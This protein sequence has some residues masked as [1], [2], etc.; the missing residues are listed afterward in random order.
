MRKTQRFALSHFAVHIAHRSSMPHVSLILLQERR[1]LIKDMAQYFIP[2]NDRPVSL[3]PSL[4][5]DGDGKLNRPATARRNS[6]IETQAAVRPDLSQKAEPTQTPYP[7]PS[8]AGNPTVVP[9]AVLEQF[10]F[11]FLIRHPR[12]SIP[13]Y[14]RCTIPP[15]D[16]L[17]GFHN[18]RS[19]EAGYAELRQMFD[20][21]RRMGYVGP[22]IAGEE[23]ETD[24]NGANG[25]S[26]QT[27][28]CVVDA[29]DLL[30]KPS[31]VIEAFCKSVGIDYSP[32]MLTWT[33]EQ[34]KEA[35]EAFAKWKGFHED[36]LHSHDLKPRKHVSAET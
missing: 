32:Q 6:H 26:S 35:E 12:N 5:I 24:K 13:S 15:L 14:Y 10:H 31:E 3:A 1:L 29:D 23:S 27:E 20:F 16:D 34:D 4:L 19:D 2:P 33:E 30:D 17:T 25:G 36:A 21:L 18:F 7:T 9:S 28:I 11:A 8:E 22:K